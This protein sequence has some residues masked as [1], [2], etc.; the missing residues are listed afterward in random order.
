MLIVYT[1]FF[2]HV[3][4]EALCDILVNCMIDRKKEQI[5]VPFRRVKNEI[6]LKL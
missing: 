5:T 2:G 1:A 3:F 4:G 6:N